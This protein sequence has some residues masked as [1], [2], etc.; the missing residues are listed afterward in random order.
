M[1]AIVKRG[2]ISVIEK[3]GIELKQRGKN[4]IGLCPFHAER[5]PSFCVDS[6]RQH[7]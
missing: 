7:W 3:E 4:F 1:P 5:T 2:L 6:E